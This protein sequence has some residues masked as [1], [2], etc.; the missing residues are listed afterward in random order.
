MKTLIYLRSN[1]NFLKIT[2]TFLFSSELGKEVEHG[3]S[4][5]QTLQSI[6]PHMKL[7]T[8]SALQHGKALIPASKTQTRV[9]ALM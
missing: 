5:N 2:K 6:H 3:H 8:S 9:H 4:R 7:S 1:P